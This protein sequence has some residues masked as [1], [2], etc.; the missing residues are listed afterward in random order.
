M[1]LRNQIIQQQFREKSAFYVFKGATEQ[2]FRLFQS[3]ENTC[4]LLGNI[5]YQR[6]MK[7]KI[8]SR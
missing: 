2:I 1:T 8:N 3:I 6:M 7:T 5:D 4:F